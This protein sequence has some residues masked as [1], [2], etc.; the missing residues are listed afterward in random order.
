MLAQ[1]GGGVWTKSCMHLDRVMC[2]H[3]NVSEPHL[4]VFVEVYAHFLNTR[5]SMVLE[6]TT[7][8]RL[9]K[10]RQKNGHPHSHGV[11]R[12]VHS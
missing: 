10:R 12:L 7:S 5:C 3:A 8:D 2:K 6:P 9:A 11:G 4:G 1:G